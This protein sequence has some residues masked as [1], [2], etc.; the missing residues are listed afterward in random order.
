MKH[1]RSETGHSVLGD[2]NPPFGTSAG[3][4]DGDR[5]DPSEL[6]FSTAALSW[7]YPPPSDRGADVTGA[8]LTFP[9]ESTSS[10]GL[11]SVTPAVPSETGA[12]PRLVITPVGGGDGGSVLSAGPGADAGNDAHAMY[13]DAARNQFDLTGGTTSTGA[14]IKIGILSDSFDT[15]SPGSA[16]QDEANGWLPANVT[17]LRDDPYTG[18]IDEGRAMAELIHQVAPGAEIYFYSAEGSEQTMANGI[19][20]L[21]A[22]GCQIIVDDVSYLNEPIYQTGDVIQK[23]VTTAVNAGVDYFTA[24]TNNGTD[25]YESTFDPIP[26]YALPGTGL[27]APGTRTVSNVSGG[28][29]YETVDLSPGT[30]YFDLQWGQPYSS[31]GGGAGTDYTIGVAVYEIIDGAEDFAFTVDNASLGGDPVNVVGLTNSSSSTIQIAFAYY[32][33]SGTLPIVDASETT[34]FKMIAINSNSAFLGPNQG[35]G[36]GVSIGHNQEP[37]ANSVGAIYYGNTPVNGVSTPVQE[38]FS[39]YGPGEYLYNASGTLLTPPQPLGAPAISAPDGSVTDVPEFAG[40][41]FGTSAAAPNAAGVAALLLQEDG[42]LTTT[43]VTYLLES[44]AIPTGNTLNGGAGLIDAQAAVAV[45][46]TAINTNIW[47]GQG[48]TAS[49]SLA[50]NWSDDRVPSIAD[51]VTIGNGLGALSG[52]Y[53]VTYD[54]SSS[55]IGGLTIDGAS[56]FVSAIPSLLVSAATSLTVSSITLGMFGSLDIAGTLIDTGAIGPVS[57]GPVNGV[58]VDGGGELAVGAG[59]EANV[60]LSSV[61]ARI[62]FASTDP[63][64][65]TTGLTGTVSNFGL[66]DMIELSGLTYDPHD[67]IKVVGG[68]ARIVDTANSDALVARFGLTGSFSGVMLDPGSGDDTIVVACFLRGT[69]IATP[70]GE[71][72]VEMLAIGDLVTTASGATR[73]IRWIGR[74]AYDA[75]FAARNPSV[76]PIRISADALAPGRPSRDLV[77]SAKHAFYLDGVL[78]PAEALV[79]GMSIRRDPPGAVHYVHIELDSHDV[80]LADGAASETFCDTGNRFMFEN[81]NEY[82]SLY[83]DDRRPR[84]RFCADRLEAGDVADAIRARLARRAAAARIGGALLDAD[85]VLL[86]PTCSGPITWNFMVP[87]G[88]GKIR[89]VS[90]SAVPARVGRGAD[91]RSLGFAVSGITLRRDQMCTRIAPDDSCLHDGWHVPEGGHRWTD[92][93]AVLPVTLRGDGPI[94]ISLIA[95]PFLPEFVKCAPRDVSRAAA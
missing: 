4:V 58:R 59:F 19:A 75:R 92:G 85:G 1:D 6:P 57:G 49:W 91:E 88:T 76:A 17:I 95:R 63:T 55:T 15:V 18:G 82:A 73:R 2:G 51:T 40:G 52:A 78:V 77:V 29:P 16:A 42:Y 14:V 94:A 33:S 39:S 67:A 26:N 32:L 9:L 61:D 21:T 7:S 37:G 11:P 5:A 74:R 23:A 64:T 8:L 89:L 62:E 65:L 84:W 93:D 68:E 46:N 31:I 50:A 41:F 13:A 34:L 70:A 20:A 90:P 28:S 43:Q 80:I 25:Y 45:A 38:S 22:A 3:G 30:T 60:A 35:V 66:G 48:G 83:P 10:G 87:A 86:R 53:S 44:T 79:N 81:A 71:R 72:P 27:G 56:R 12:I 47:T 36:S 69:N 54:R 24:V